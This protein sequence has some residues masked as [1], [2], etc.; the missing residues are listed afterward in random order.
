MTPQEALRAILNKNI[1]VLG[2]CTDLSDFCEGMNFAIKLLKKQI[3]KKPTHQD[4]WCGN[5]LIY[6]CPNEHRV[7]KGAPYCKYCG[8]AL[9]WSETE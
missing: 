8:Q 7:S 3:P 4:L 2:S 5:D 1:E 6:H 9:D